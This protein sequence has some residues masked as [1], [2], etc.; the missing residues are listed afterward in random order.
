MRRRQEGKRG[1]GKRR[2]GNDPQT[3]S[4]AI[5]FLPLNF[6]V[7]IIK[8]QGIKFVTLNTK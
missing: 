7:I 5:A 4:L 6:S 2:G 1:E 8:R 3:K